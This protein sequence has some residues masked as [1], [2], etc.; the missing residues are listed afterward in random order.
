MAP[1]PSAAELV[2]DAFRE[3]WPALALAAALLVLIA[4]L[5]LP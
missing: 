1:H 4:A 5:F 3:P 2:R